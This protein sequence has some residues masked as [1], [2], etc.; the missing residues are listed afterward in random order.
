MKARM[1]FPDRNADVRTAPSGHDQDL[2][3][4]L[5]LDTVVDAMAGEDELIGKVATRCL[6]A[7]PPAVEEILYRQDVLRDCIDHPDEIRE[8]YEL[9][10]F[11]AETKRRTRM[12]LA[13][14]TKPSSILYWSTGLLREL[15]RCLGLLHDYAQRNRH[16]FRADGLSTLMADIDRDLDTD[17]LETVRGHL[18]ELRFPDGVH[19]T[20]SV[21]ADG[22]GTDYV[23]RRP[24]TI[25]W[26]WRRLVDWRPSSATYT[27]RIAD[28]DDLGAQTLD[29]LQNTGLN[30][31]ADAAA[32]SAEHILDFFD[33]LRMETAFYVGC[34]NLHDRVGR[35]GP[36][37]FPRP[38]PADALALDATELVDAGLLLRGVV[39]LVPNDLHATGSRLIMITGANQGGKSTLLRAIGLA[40]LMTAAGMFVTAE[41]FRLSAAP[42]LVSHFRREEDSELSHGKLDEELSRLSALLDVLEPGS[43]A[44][45]NESFS[46]TNELEGSQLARDVIEA[47][48]E[49]GVRVVFVTHLFTLADGLARAPRDDA[50]F[51]RAERLPDGSRTF[52]VAPGPPEPTSHGKDIFTEV[53]APAKSS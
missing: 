49:S 8:L 10:S 46:S 18:D 36:I 50:L 12:S 51:L 1:L 9:A 7:T 13:G 37:C 14:V 16:L 5:G 22:M 32:R 21:G 30:L 39:D 15:A 35:T 40:Q 24:A 53:F 31:V 23:L 43:L 20:A 33:Q 48:T 25:R 11:G 3:R 6:L 2:V 52:R 28:R 38:A 4:D 19:L 44:L 29:R 45:F 26:S 47:L 42:R 27:Y 17:Y 34:L 41:D